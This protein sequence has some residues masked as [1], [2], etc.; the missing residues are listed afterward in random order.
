MVLGIVFGL[1]AALSQCFSYVFS[2]KFVHK[3]GNSF[4]L[5]VISHFIMGIF[6]AICLGFLLIENNLP[7]LKVYWRE[8]LLVDGFYVLGQMS[9]FLA[10]SKTE[11]SRLAPLLGLKIVF[12]SLFSI[13]FLGA[14]LFSGQWVAIILC[15]TG[16]VMSNWSG[17]SI[18]LS[19]ALWLIGAVAGYSLSDICIKELI[20]RIQEGTGKNSEA[21][22]LAASTSYCFLGIVSVPVIISCRSMKIKLLKPALPFSCFWFAAML[23]LF[24]CFGYIG[25][26]FGNIVQ[27]GR[28]IIAVV[29]GALIAK[30]GWSEYEEKLPRS[31]LV[32]RIAAAMLITGAIILFA[33][34]K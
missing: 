15:L 29:I 16:A 11:A 31:L 26:L 7:P 14:E 20:D 23:F 22:F 10:I 8:L 34:S 1:L 9:F 33:L 2:K 17:K 5:L 27:S 4:Q 18:P 13:M 12:I 25:P 32:R 19:G 24:A 6:S 21:V 3:D 28:G 30:F